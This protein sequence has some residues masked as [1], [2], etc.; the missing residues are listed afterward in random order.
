MKQQT[1]WTQIPWYPLHGKRGPVNTR[2]LRVKNGICFQVFCRAFTAW[3]LL[4]GHFHNATAFVVL[5]WHLSFPS[6]SVLNFALSCCG[7][8]TV[9]STPATGSTIHHL[10]MYA[11]EELF[12][13]AMLNAKQCLVI[14]GA[15]TKP[16]QH[17]S[18]SCS[19]LLKRDCLKVCCVCT[20]HLVKLCFGSGQSSLQLHWDRRLR[21]F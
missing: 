11:P 14:I 10:W 3:R 17:G 12:V 4:R 1:P 15:I 16:F 5:Y 20:A 13:Y 21:F 18:W 7:S 6:G 9:L 2:K 8:V 19:L